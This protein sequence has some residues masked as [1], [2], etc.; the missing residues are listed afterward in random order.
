MSENNPNTQKGQQE[1]KNPIGDRGP[2]RNADPDQRGTHG[3]PAKD[4][5]QSGSW[6]PGEESNAGDGLEGEAAEREPDRSKDQSNIILD[7]A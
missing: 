3:G 4:E 5:G 6:R 1:G 7:N 2:N